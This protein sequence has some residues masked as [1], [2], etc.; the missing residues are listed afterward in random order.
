MASTGLVS[1]FLN[2]TQIPAGGLSSS[3]SLSATRKGPYQIPPSQNV[4]T[5]RYQESRTYTVNLPTGSSVR[6]SDV[7]DAITAVLRAQDTDFTRLE[8]STRSGLLKIEDV[9][10]SGRGSSISLSESAAL[11]GFE[12]RG[13]RGR[14]IHPGWGL[15]SE[16][17]RVDGEGNPIRDKGIRFVSPPKTTGGIYRVTYTMQ[18]SRCSRCLGNLVENDI[19]PGDNGEYR[20]V[21]N[22]DLLVQASQKFLLTELRSNPYHP[23]YGS[24]LKGK[25]GSK[26]TGAVEAAIQEDI[27]GALQKFQALQVK[28]AKYQT[29]T[30]EERLQSVDSIQVSPVDGDPTAYLV[31]VVVRNASRRTVNVTIVFAV[32][33]TVALEGTNQ[34]S[35]GTEGVGLDPRTRIRD[36]R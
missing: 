12:Q 34:L 6:A 32:P 2:E 30:A 22:E 8:V 9:R 24:E 28:Q 35:L 29:V 5:I 20:L 15:F 19:R 10:S 16:V 7:K 36:L 31:D 11:I 21:R 17:T 26:S 23:W 4:L 33:G 1:V 13:S 14:D 18:P 25:I 3:A 27:R